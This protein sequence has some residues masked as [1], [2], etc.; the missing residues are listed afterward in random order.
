MLCQELVKP[1][2][3]HRAQVGDKL[4]ALTFRPLAPDFYDRPKVRGSRVKIRMEKMWK[5]LLTFTQLPEDA[6]AD[7]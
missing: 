7:R 3:K 6:C 5:W 1:V 2:Y 4:R